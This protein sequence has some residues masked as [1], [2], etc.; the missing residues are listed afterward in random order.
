[1]LSKWL[2]V[3]YSLQFE[4]YYF[5]FII[6]ANP[7]LNSLMKESQVTLKCFMQYFYGTYGTLNKIKQKIHTCPWIYEMTKIV[8]VHALNDLETCDF[9]M[10][11]FSHANHTSTNLTK[12]FSWKLNKFTLFTHSLVAWNLGNLC[13]QAVSIFL[14][15]EMKKKI[16]STFCNLF[17]KFSPKCENFSH[18]KNQMKLLETMLCK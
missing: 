11:C 18:K 4:N 16:K 3:R 14:C 10:F 13:K 5:I 6:P 1:M 8:C 12:F 17:W 15:F 2:P 7:N 9:N